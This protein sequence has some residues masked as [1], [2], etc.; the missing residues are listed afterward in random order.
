MFIGMLRA[1]TY[2]DRSDITL[3]N[4]VL[5]VIDILNSLIHRELKDDLI[6]IPAHQCGLTFH[7]QNLDDPTKPKK[8]ASHFL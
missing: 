1:L 2:C 6:I 7:S 3:T 8:S 4:V 5:P